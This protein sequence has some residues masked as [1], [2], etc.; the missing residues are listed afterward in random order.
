M[1]DQLDPEFFD[2]D[3]WLSDAKRPERSVVVYKRA[4]LQAELDRLEERIQNIRA[5]PEEERSLADSPSKLEG[6]YED[7]LAEISASKLEVTVRGLISTE[8][9][10]LKKKHDASKDG[11]SEFSYKVLAEAVVSPKLDVAGWR[12]VHEVIGQGQLNKILNAYAAA[13][14]GIPNPSAAFLRKSSTS[15]NGDG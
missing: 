10:K 4:D 15:R 3:A 13:T 1:T 14:D 6:E 5:I 7:L 12:R 2:L 9:E 11:S 8:V